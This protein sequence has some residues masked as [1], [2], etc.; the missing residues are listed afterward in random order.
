MCFQDTIHK[1]SCAAAKKKNPLSKP[2]K[3]KA[4]K[5]HQIAVCLLVHN[6][7]PMTKCACFFCE[8]KGSAWDPSHDVQ[9]K[10]A[11]NNLRTAVE[12]S[13]NGKL[14]VKLCTARDPN[15]AHAIDAVSHNGC[16]TNRVTN[17]LC[18]S[19]DDQM[20]R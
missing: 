14:K 8:C 15:D 19:I 12:K 16:W 11:G 13:A 9:T 2:L 1:K 6:Q 3:K 20:Q 18:K 5:V 17:V 4:V 10:R 7:S